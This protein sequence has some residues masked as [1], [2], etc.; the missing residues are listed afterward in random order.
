MAPGEGAV[1]RVWQGRT[2]MANAGA[3][4]Q[5]LGTET[6]PGLTKITGFE[7][8]FVLRRVN[9]QTVEYI[10]MTLWSSREAIGAFAGE[11]A[12]CAVIPDAAAKVLDE[13]E[14]RARHFE[15]ALTARANE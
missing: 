11:D 9:G 13:W 7:Q 15:V 4:E 6:L 5:H 10:V 12:E 8:A 3:Y 1:A 14:E 2:T